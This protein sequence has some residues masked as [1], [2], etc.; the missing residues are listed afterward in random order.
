MYKLEDLEVFQLSVKLSDEV[1]NM[2]IKWKPLA[3]DTIRRQLIRSTD[4]IAANIAEG[5]GRFS[6]KEN[7]QFCMYS[8]G[9]IMETK[10]WLMKG[11]NRNLI[12]E[13]QCQDLMSQLETI[14]IK[15]NAYLKF[16]QKSEQ[17]LTNKN[18]KLRD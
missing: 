1:W 15:L 16:I 10:S 5:Y 2:V 12:T 14:H 3:Q 8:R 18:R 6:L 11:R 7:R 17:R 4:S 13:L 9:S